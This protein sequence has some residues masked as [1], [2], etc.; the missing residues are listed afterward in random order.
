[1]E[2]GSVAKWIDLLTDSHDCASDCPDAPAGDTCGASVAYETDAF[3]GD[4]RDEPVDHWAACCDLC[5]NTEECKS[6]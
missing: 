1:M 5:F 6:W 2:A 3:G 4:L